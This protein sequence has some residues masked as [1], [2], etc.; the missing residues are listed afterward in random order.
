MIVKD[1]KFNEICDNDQVDQFGF[2][3]LAECLKNG[4]Y[5]SKRF[6]IQ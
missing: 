3:D 4:D 6:K 2:V 5:D 1:L